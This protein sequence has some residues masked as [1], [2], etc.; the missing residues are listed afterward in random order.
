LSSGWAHQRY[1]G[2]RV[3][4]ET[5]AIRLLQK[6]RGPVKQ[7]LVLLTAN[8]TTEL[9]HVLT[10][11][12]ARSPMSEVVIHD[13]DDVLGGQVCI[14]GVQFCVAETTDRVL[15]VATVVIDLT[16]S[17]PELL[18]GMS[19]NYRREITRAQASGVVVDV[20]ERPSAD[21]LERFVNAVGTLARE[22][23][24]AAY[25]L[26]QVANMFSG[27]NSVLLVARKGAEELNLAHVYTA[28]SV[29]YYMSG[30]A[31][32]REHDGSGKAVHW[33]GMQHLRNRGFEWYDLGG[34][35]SRRADDGIYNFKR[36]FGGRVVSLGTEWRNAS[37]IIDHA[38]DV[39]GRLRRVT[40]GV[41]R[42]DEA[43]QDR[44]G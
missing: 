38:R 24:F 35:A 22:R 44:S 37:P 39:R 7:N 4:Y 16:H 9:A 42:R 25:S 14:D 27:G 17:E 40:Q 26:G 6:R 41:R 18:A 28:D 34:V 8:G 12:S 36:R 31:L 32:S 5:P 2:W 15:N 23:R 1:L 43:A 10:E 20:H 21:L 30:V 19:A 13:F 11:T 3:A 29:G 33:A